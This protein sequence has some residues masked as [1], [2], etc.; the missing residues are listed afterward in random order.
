M[1]FLYLFQFSKFI[2]ISFWGVYDTELI[3]FANLYQIFA[4]G[5][6]KDKIISN[7]TENETN[8]ARVH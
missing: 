5:P 3:G 7:K 1:I 4:V 8:L 2:N 6:V